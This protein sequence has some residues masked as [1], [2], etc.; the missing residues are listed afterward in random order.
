M[1]LYP[2]PRVRTA[3]IAVIMIYLPTIIIFVSLRYV[4]IALAERG[5]RIFAKRVK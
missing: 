4:L 1:I 5:L 3:S 2:I